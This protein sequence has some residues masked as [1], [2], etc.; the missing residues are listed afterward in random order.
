MGVYLKEECGK[1]VTITFILIKQIYLITQRRCLLTT[2][3]SNHLQVVIDGVGKPHRDGIPITS[4]EFRREIHDPIGVSFV[5]CFD[6]VFTFSFA[7][8]EDRGA[9]TKTSHIK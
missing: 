4:P 3:I 6:I 5:V 1:W 7:C 2:G 8:Q 9:L